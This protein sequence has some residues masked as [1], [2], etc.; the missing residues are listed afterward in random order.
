MVHYLKEFCINRKILI[1]EKNTRFCCI[2]M[3]SYLIG[4]M[5]LTNLNLQK[6]N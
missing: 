3:S 6:E 4:F 1:N 5:S 2:I